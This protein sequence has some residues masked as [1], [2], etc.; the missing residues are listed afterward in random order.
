MVYLSLLAI[1]GR[2]HLILMEVKS[3]KYPLD[4][5]LTLCQHYGVIDAEAYLLVR[6]G[7][8]GSLAQAIKL[9]FEVSGL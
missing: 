2:H 6:S 1:T 4:A 8:H 9:Y 5:A 3:E 7:G